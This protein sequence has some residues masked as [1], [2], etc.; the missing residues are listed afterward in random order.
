MP[1]SCRVFAGDR[2][3]RCISFT[4]Q[5]DTCG[6]DTVQC[7]RNQ[8]LLPR[9]SRDCEEVQK[10]STNASSKLEVRSVSRALV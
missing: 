4:L 9:V 1:S 7:R 3:N 8:S 5:C 10:D 6:A 2:Y